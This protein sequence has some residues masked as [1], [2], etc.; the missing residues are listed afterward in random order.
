M[1]ALAPRLMRSRLAAASLSPLAAVLAAACGGAG[2]SPLARATVDTLPSGVVRVMSDAP[3]GWRHTVGWRL[4]EVSR[5]TGE[6]GGPSE[7]INPQALAMDETGRVFLSDQNPAVIK[8]Y[9]RDGRFVRAIGREGA[10]PGEFR[11]AFIAVR[12]GLLAVQDPRVNRLSLFDTAGTYLRSWRS[13]CCYWSDI[14]IDRDGR[15]YVPTAVTIQPGEE[16]RG[17]AYT[18]YDSVG[19]TLDT[20]FLPRGPEG[21]SWTVRGGSG[22]IVTS[23][24]YTPGIVY[25]LRP[26]GGFVYGVSSSSQL[27]VSLSG[28]DTTRL[29][30]RTWTV[31]PISGDQRREAVERQI[32]SLSGGGGWND[33]ALRAAFKLEDVPSSLPAF[34]GVKVDEADNCWVRLHY[35]ADTARTHFDVFDPEGAWLGRVVSPVVFPEYGRQAWGRSEVVV[36]IESEDG[37]PVIVRYRIEKGK[38]R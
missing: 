10:G 11:V 22:S 18:R 14:G 1:S 7:V 31:E 16:R 2:V 37:R 34:A 24:P 5:I 26:S 15:V 19:T 27:A 38:A 12:R 35:L 23:V 25:A 6:E 33:A 21:K 9:E 32:R 17:N 13:S 36:A 29:F 4:V 3:T 20:L 8:G 28:A 30:R